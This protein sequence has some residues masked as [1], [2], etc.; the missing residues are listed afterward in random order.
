MMILVPWTESSQQPFGVKVAYDPRSLS[1][2]ACRRS[3]DAVA[4]KECA[5][6]LL[7]AILMGG[8]AHSA[9]AGAHGGARAG[10]ETWF[11][12][13]WIFCYY[14]AAARL[15][16]QVRASAQSAVIERLDHDVDSG[17]DSPL[18]DWPVDSCDVI[19]IAQ[20]K[21]FTHVAFGTPGVGFGLRMMEV[22]AVRRPV[23]E[24]PFRTVAAGSQ[25]TTRVWVAGDD[26]RIYVPS[27]QASSRH[28]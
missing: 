11:P 22:E 16:L 25:S 1:A 18:M 9:P 13:A 8:C 12:T 4:D 10:A 20:A 26:G 2:R 5:G 6:G 3:A 21:Q 19:R 23:W 24:T 15:A 27:T 14:D 28:P 7:R 17:D